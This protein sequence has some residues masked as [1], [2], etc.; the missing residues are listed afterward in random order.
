VVQ[1]NHVSRSE[2][3]YTSGLELGS[4]LR[5]TLNL[6]QLNRDLIDIGETCP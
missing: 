3:Y 5:S 1:L 6:V 2:F 4:N